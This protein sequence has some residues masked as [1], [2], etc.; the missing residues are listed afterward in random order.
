MPRAMDGGGGGSDDCDQYQMEI[1]TYTTT[2]DRT[3]P[4]LFFLDNGGKL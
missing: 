1:H 4:P 2:I 3:F